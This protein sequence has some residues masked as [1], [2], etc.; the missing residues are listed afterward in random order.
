MKGN[1]K[2]GN[3]RW[4]SEQEGRRLRYVR[5][6]GLRKENAERKKI[7]EAMKAGVNGR[8]I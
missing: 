5:D 4:M 2:G 1:N 7:D 8:S 3:G 6:L